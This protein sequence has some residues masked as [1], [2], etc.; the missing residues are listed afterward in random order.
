MKDRFA[1][2]CNQGS[3]TLFDA[4]A[5]AEKA[6]EA[7]RLNTAGAVVIDL[8]ALA[9]AIDRTKRNGTLSDWLPQEV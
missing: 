7:L 2:I 6:A 5:V 8:E 9:F 3:V 1:V 4:H